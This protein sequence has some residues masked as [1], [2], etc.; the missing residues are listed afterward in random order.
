[1]AI[2]IKYQDPISSDLKSDDIVINVKEGTVLY[3]NEKGDLYKLQ[4]DNLNIPPTQEETHFDSTI[5]ASKLYLQGS[6][7]DVYMGQRNGSPN[8]AYSAHSI[9]L[10]I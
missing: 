10:K 3:K 6:N 4:G 7:N 5:S 8:Q 1:M 9:D 2:K